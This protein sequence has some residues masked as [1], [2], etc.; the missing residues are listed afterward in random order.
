LARTIPY[1]CGARGNHDVN[2]FALDPE[3]R[4]I[5]GGIKAN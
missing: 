1:R 5:E 2:S 3:R 4:F